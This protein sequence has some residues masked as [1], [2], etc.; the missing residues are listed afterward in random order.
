MI[1][2]N[3]KAFAETIG[4]IRVHG[5]KP[6]YHHKVIGCNSRLDALQAAVLLVKIEIP[7]LVD[8]S[9]KG[10][11]GLLSQ[12]FSENGLTEFIGLPHVQ[13]GNFHI[14]NQFVIRVKRRDEFTALLLPAGIGT[15]I[16]Y[17]IPLHLQECYRH[18]GHK[19]AIFPNPKRQ[20]GDPCPP[21]LPELSTEQQEYVVGKIR[22]FMVP[23]QKSCG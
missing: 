19:K 16:Y 3:D 18:L 11:R 4:I 5:S 15:E 1:T 14:Y 22:G 8:R 23:K 9:T 7:R 2:T 13:E 12:R 6:K 21:H 20:P 17:P 10:K